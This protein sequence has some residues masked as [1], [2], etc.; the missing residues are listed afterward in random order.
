MVGS[1][2]VYYKNHA[3][4][5]EGQTNY[6]TGKA[7]H[8]FRPKVYDD[9]GAEVWAEMSYNN[10]VLTVT[11][12]QVFLDTANYPV[13]VD[14][15]FGYTTIGG[16]TANSGS[17]I[18]S[19]EYNGGHSQAGSAGTVTSISLYAKKNVIDI[20]FQGGLYR[21]SD[22]GFVTGNGSAVTVNNTTPQWWDST[23]MS[24]AIT[25][26]NYYVTFIDNGNSADGI[27]FYF[28]SV[29]A[30]N[31]PLSSSGVTYPTFPATAALTSSV[32]EI[33]I[34]ATYT[35]GGGSTPT[36]IYGA[37]LQGATIY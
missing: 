29:A 22:A 24:V 18:G 12:P 19:N 17:G 30:A 15:T 13:I 9:N 33:S 27:I 28:D 35:A 7:Y 4:H 14:P 10:G 8:I 6:A 36:T 31:R 26:Q 37:T 2:A 32:R 5:I 1:Y 21:V 34:Y 20:S 16:T 25:A 3:N 23:G 11:V